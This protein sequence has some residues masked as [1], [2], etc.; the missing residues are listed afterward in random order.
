VN[1][2]EHVYEVV[3]CVPS[4]HVVTYGQVAALC[5]YPG[6]ARHVGHALATCDE[7]DVPWY[8]VL[9][10]SGRISLPLDERQRTQAELLRA[11]GVEVVELRVRLARFRWE[12][13]SLAFAR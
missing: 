12:P 5:G 13:G 11:E 2:R 8:R 1:F 6:R 10:A 4:G 7:P 9:N 3:R